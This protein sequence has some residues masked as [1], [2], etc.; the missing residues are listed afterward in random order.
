MTLIF[1][2]IGPNAYK[3][4]VF[5]A[6]FLKHGEELSGSPLFL[7]SKCKLTRHSWG[8]HTVVKKTM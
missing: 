7:L 4:F 1:K 2:Y 6:C 8:E 3:N 5:V